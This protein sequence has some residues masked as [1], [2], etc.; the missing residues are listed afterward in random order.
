MGGPWRHRTAR[1]RTAGRCTEGEC[2]A[3]WCAAG[4]WQ[5]AL[6]HGRESLRYCPGARWCMQSAKDRLEAALAHDGA[7]LVKALQ[8]IERNNSTIRGLE[9]EVGGQGE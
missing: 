8:V 7:R 6:N 9:H 5:E 3:G 1:W 4:W 2:T